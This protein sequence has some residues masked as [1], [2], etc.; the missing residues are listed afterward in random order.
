MRS[1]EVLVS[2][3]APF[4]RMRDAPPLR[5]ML[6]GAVFLNPWNIKSTLWE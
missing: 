5:V 2:L 1:L 4:G 6:V 3:R